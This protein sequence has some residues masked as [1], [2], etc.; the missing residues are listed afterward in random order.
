MQSILICM[1]FN[2]IIVSKDRIG[3]LIIDFTVL[4]LLPYLTTTSLCK[5]KTVT[6]LLVT[7]FI[8]Y[9]F[10]RVLVVLDKLFTSFEFLNCSSVKSLSSRISK[11]SGLNSGPNS[12]FSITIL[13]FF[14]F[15]KRI[16]SNN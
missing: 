15:C 7:V 14:F 5:R 16:T 13:L 1:G 3:V 12:S 2:T 6:L 11:S 10:F 4:N 9:L 8:F